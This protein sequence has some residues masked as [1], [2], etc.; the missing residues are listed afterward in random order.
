MARKVRAA[1]V[2]A[3]GYSGANVIPYA[4]LFENIEFV[5]VCDIDLALARRAARRIG[6][7]LATDDYREVLSRPDIAMVELQTPNYL[8]AAQAAAAFEAGKHVFS[9]KPM[10]RTLREAKRMIAAGRKAGRLLGIY[11]D[12]YDDPSLWDIKAA[13]GKGFIGR[14]AGFRLRYAHQGGLGLRPGEW[15]KSAERTGG[16]CFLLLTVHL[17]NAV[18]WIFDSRITRVTGFMKTLMAPMEGDDSAAGALELANGLVGAADA[19]YVAAGTPDI[20]NTVLEIRGTQGAIRQQRDDG[21]IYVY[22]D[23]RK[24][25]GRLVRYDRPG[26][27]MKFTRPRDGRRERKVRPT[28]HERFAEAVLGGQPYLVPGEAGLRDLAVCLAMAESSRTG[29]AIDLED[30]IGEIP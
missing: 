6:A 5:A 3:G 27:T 23:K 1:L 28:V 15:R 25:R 18:Q 2:G 30:F 22:S 26:R 11:M 14:P 17:V 24:F 16:G 20:P 13:V 8:H 9:Q 29:R 21:L 7:S 19:S 12:G 10:A 4:D